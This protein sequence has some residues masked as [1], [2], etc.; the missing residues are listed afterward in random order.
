MSKT[1]SLEIECD[2][3]AINGTRHQRVVVNLDSPT[4]ADLILEQFEEADINDWIARNRNPEDI[5]PTKDLEKWAES[6]G[7]VKPD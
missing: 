2:N 5:F 7:Y 4:D 3:V 6:E 1:K